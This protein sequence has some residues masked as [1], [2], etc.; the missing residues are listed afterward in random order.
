ML[1]SEELSRVAHELE[2][3]LQ[4]EQLLGD[5][6]A[7]FV[8]LSPE[9]TYDQISESMK[10][11]VEALGHDRSTLA[12]FD[13]ES[14]RIIHSHT[15]SGKK[16]FTLKR[17]EDKLLPWYFRRLRQGKSVFFDCPEELPPEADRERQFCAAQGIKSHIG[18]PLIAAGSV[19]GALNFSSFGHVGFWQQDILARIQ[20]I[21]EVFANAILH[22]RDREAINEALAES[23]RL[24]AQLER[25][26]VYLREQITLKHDHESM[27]GESLALCKALG[28]AERVAVTDTPVL[29]F[30]ETGTGK[31]LFAEEIHRLSARKKKSMVVVN[32]ASL[33]STLIESELFGRE[34]GAYTGAASAQH[35]R[36]EIADRST[37][38]LDEIGELPI[39]LQSKLLR[40]LEDGRFQKLGSPK[41]IAVDVRII[42]ATNRDL[43]KE[44]RDGRFRED[45]YHR[46]NVFPIRIPP[47]RERSE[48]IP[49]LVWAF[50]DDLGHRM[51]KKI[52]SVPRSVMD[53]LQQYHWPG[54]IREL[55]NVIE[56]GMILTCDE[57]LHIELPSSQQNPLGH[58]QTLKECERNHILRALQDAAWRIRGPGGA[59]E[60]LDI[61]P[62]TLE[63]RMAKLGIKRPRGKS[64]IS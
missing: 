41:T 11:L 46:L 5:L 60:L 64:N 59:S 21:G 20:L 2:K 30:G 10:T 3:R 43:E 45:L 7:T 38:F 44:M 4:F 1:D 27:V 13:E 26:N 16:P 57:T 32:C 54:N 37:L 40:V 51:G 39:E 36:F 17:M 49:L 8:N 53:R 61:K 14:A 33:P 29:L 56:R 6:S 42:A 34:A 52:A 63:A 18:I 28:D 50:V 12:E 15:V 22:R 35:G 31:E 19:L 62:T 9:E 25:E 47:L 55:R 23:E 24:R 58:R 48:D